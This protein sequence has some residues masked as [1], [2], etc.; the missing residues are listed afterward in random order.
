[1]P[2]QATA[3][4][5]SIGTDGQIC[6]INLRYGKLDADLDRRRAEIWLAIRL[7]RHEGQPDAAGMQPDGNDPSDDE[8]DRR[9]VSGIVKRLANGN[10]EIRFDGDVGRL[11][12]FFLRHR[13]R[14]RQI[15]R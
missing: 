5:V 10:G 6:R 1:R 7:L 14:S 9:H 12:W 3:S 8:Q 13:S 2:A 11:V 15:D 4:R